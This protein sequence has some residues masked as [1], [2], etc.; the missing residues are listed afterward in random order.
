MLGVGMGAW[1]GDQG[2][3]A[4]GMAC[5]RVSETEE[6]KGKS[7]VLHILPAESLKLAN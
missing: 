2:H 1:S 5:K 7:L 3:E 4:E 6:V